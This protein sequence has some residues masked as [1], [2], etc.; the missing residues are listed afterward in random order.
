MFE[1]RL[2]AEKGMVGKTGAVA[3]FEAY[4]DE[5]GAEKAREANKKSS[6]GPSH[7][8]IVPSR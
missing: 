3:A 7:G 2:D 6:H 8:G 1:Q 4:A 5:E